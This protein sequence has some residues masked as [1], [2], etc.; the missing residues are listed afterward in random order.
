MICS[1]LETIIINLIN[2]S[3]N[4]KLSCEYDSLFTRLKVHNCIMYIVLQQ[5]KRV[6]DFSDTDTHA[7]L[8]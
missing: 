4:I 5:N 1:A 8:Q 7:L 3:V 6:D 2:A